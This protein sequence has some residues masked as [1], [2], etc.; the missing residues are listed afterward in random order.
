MQFYALDTREELM[1]DVLMQSIM[2]HKLSEAFDAIIEIKVNCESHN[3]RKYSQ[4]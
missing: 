4:M 1:E 2:A 3:T